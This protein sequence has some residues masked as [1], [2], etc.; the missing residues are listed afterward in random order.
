MTDKGQRIIIQK[1][2]LTNNGAEVCVELKYADKV[3]KG[4]S[5]CGAGEYAQMTGAANALINAINSIIPTPIVT[6]VAEIQ[7]VRF[8]SLADVVIVT[9]VGIKIKGQEMLFSG[10]AKMDNSLLQTVVRAALDAV[11]RPIGMVL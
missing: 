5:P 6:K 4:K 2:A 9:L 3:Y 8:Q 10:S 7:Q 11:N 1:V